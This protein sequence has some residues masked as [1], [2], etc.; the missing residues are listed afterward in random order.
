MMK[1]LLVISY[2]VVD[3]DDDVDVDDDDDDYDGDGD[4]CGDHLLG[5]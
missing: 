3:D 4:A 5:F 2:Q 1:V